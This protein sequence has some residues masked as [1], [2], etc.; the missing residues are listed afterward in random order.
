MGTISPWEISNVGTCG[1]LCAKKCLWLSGLFVCVSSL[2]LPIV[3]VPILKLT[4]STAIMTGQFRSSR[5]GRILAWLISWVVIGFNVYLFGMFLDDFNWSWW[6]VT[7]TGIYMIFV[8]Y[9]IYTPLD[10]SK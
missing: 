2:C 3:L 1:G 4:S 10:L 6:M 9:L 8:S 5:A 7:L